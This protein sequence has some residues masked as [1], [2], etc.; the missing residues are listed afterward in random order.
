M[1]KKA[2]KL[3]LPAVLHNPPY[4]RVRCGWCGGS[5]IMNRRGM[6][7]SDTC[8]R[9][10]GNREGREVIDYPKWYRMVRKCVGSET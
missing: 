10:H 3:K 9:C 2:T 6:I 8:N 1:A 7:Q 4:K 5:G